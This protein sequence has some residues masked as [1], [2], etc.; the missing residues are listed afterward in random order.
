MFT[1]GS[2]GDGPLPAASSGTTTAC[3]AGWGGSR[4]RTRRPCRNSGGS[5]A[6]GR[7]PP[8]SLRPEME[9]L[10]VGPA[11][12]QVGPAVSAELGSQ[13][14]PVGHP[15]NRGCWAPFPA[16]PCLAGHRCCHPTASCRSSLPCLSS[17][18]AC[19]RRPGRQPGPLRPRLPPPR[20]SRAVA[21]LGRE[22]RVERLSI[23]QRL[24]VVAHPPPQ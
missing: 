20:R 10:P 16:T 13:P 2:G 14:G 1:A 17:G 12:L 5:R 19:T 21:W 18:P 9:G 4:G 22:G 15:A 7:R 8:G 23:R 6:P 24:S 3:A 11:G